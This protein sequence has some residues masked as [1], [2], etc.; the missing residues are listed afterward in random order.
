[1][2][3]LYILFLITIFIILSLLH[4]HETFSG[5]PEY[6]KHKSSCFDC[7]IDMIKRYGLDGARKANPSKGYDDEQAAVLQAGGDIK[8]GFLAKTLKYY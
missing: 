1:M 6:L 4:I 8:A 7:E 5:I 2:K 3:L